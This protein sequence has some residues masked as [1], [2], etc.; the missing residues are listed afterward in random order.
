VSVDGPEPVEAT[1]TEVH[2]DT[3]EESVHVHVIDPP[4]VSITEPPAEVSG[5]SPVEVEG[6][7]PPDHSPV[8]S[9]AAV[10]TEEPVVA[11]ASET[12][13]EVETVS[14]AE[15]KVEADVR[16]KRKLGWRAF[17]LGGSGGTK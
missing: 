17:I 8:E 16:P 14:P 9:D 11:A 13:K 2:V 3:G 10:V 1:P 4:E 7:G 15:K 12:E 6:T 5:D